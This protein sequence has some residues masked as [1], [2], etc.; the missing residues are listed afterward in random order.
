ML[1]FKDDPDVISEATLIIVENWDAV[2]RVAHAL[3]ANRT[4]T[5]K[6]VAELVN[7]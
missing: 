6:Q 4:L 3:D 5:R 7:L 2:S 1:G